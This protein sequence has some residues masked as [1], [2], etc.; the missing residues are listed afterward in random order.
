MMRFLA[1]SLSLFLAAS[2]LAEEEL[3]QDP[4]EPLEIEPPLLIQEMPNRAPV[5]STAAAAPQLGPEQIALALEKAKKSAASGERLFRS[6]IIAKVEAEHRAMKVVR[7]ESDLAKARVQVAQENLVEQ[8][9]RFDAAEIPQSELENAKAALEEATNA[10]A[11]AVAQQEKAELEAALLNLH[12]QKKLLAM[13]SGRKSEVSRAEE[14][15]A[16]LQQ[17]KN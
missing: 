12:R 16:A 9:S 11:V 13:G 5:E 4:G 6:G 15:V 1:F 8:Q 7:L 2:L 17:Q 14:K 10:A 3:P